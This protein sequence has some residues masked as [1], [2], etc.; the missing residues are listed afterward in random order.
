VDPDPKSSAEQPC[1]DGSML[2]NAAT[3]DG[4]SCVS[5]ADQLYTSRW[6]PPQR[7]L[8]V[9][10]LLASLGCAALVLLAWPWVQHGS[11]VPRS[12]TSKDVDLVLTTPI[13]TCGAVEKDVEYHTHASLKLVTVDTAA[14][15][16]AECQKHPR[17]GVWIYGSVEPLPRNGLRTSAPNCRL[18]EFDIGTRQVK[19]IFRLGVSSGRL[20]LNKEEEVKNG[21]AGI[22]T[23]HDI[24]APSE[25]Q[26]QHIDGRRKGTA[27]AFG[28]ARALQRETVEGFEEVSDKN[29]E[30]QVVAPAVPVLFG[31][32]MENAILIGEKFMGKVLTGRK[33]GSQV[34]LTHDFGVVPI[35]NA[36]GTAYLEKR[37]VTYRTIPSGS[38]AES[39]MAPI[40]DAVVCAAS[41]AAL[42]YLD[43]HVT[44]W[45]S[46]EPRPEGCH[47]N[48]GRVWLSLADSD[49]GRGVLGSSW[50]ICS[51]GSYP[52]TTS[53]VTTTT[54]STTTTQ[55]EALW[56]HPSLF[57]FQAVRTSTFEL[58]LARQQ[59][60]TKVSVF[61]CD[62]SIVFS[63]GEKEQELGRNYHNIPVT[64]V[65]MN[66]RKRPAEAGLWPNTDDFL[67]IW[68]YLHQDGRILNHDWTAKVDPA[69]VFFPDRLR[70][71]LK[72]YTHK[73][74]WS[75]YVANCNTK[76]APGLSSPLETFSKAALQ[77][78]FRDI[79]KCRASFPTQ[80]LAENV[81][82]MKCM[83]MLGVGHVYAENLLSDSRC[84]FAPCN[85]GMKAAYYKFS[86]ASRTGAWFRCWHNSTGFVLPNN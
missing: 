73:T 20:E 57:C 63:D 34:H 19:K 27:V 71:I 58:S 15:C 7:H 70:G 25:K 67:Q 51:N 78:F 11:A 36:S 37:I 64:T 77:T 33:V 48:A 68:S 45:S 18:R 81:F 39:G 60:S 75:L 13:E 3:V 1:C 59:F 44:I 32:G 69:A 53:T 52:T 35:E 74:G 17:C 83:D 22:G 12:A 30:W 40:D 72:S 76:G 79:K 66:G 54:T 29:E 14:T 2:L 80:G 41:A 16:C 28:S 8:V 50:P 82:T 49:R 62:E 42:G 5:G 26:Q 84:T 24:A 55:N 61:A 6:C 9:I 4:T 21:I 65:L 47:L 10:T 43:H 86:D 56:G 31:P 23:N 85:D 38:C 46:G